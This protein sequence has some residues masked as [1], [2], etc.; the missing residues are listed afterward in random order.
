MSNCIYFIEFTP[1]TIEYKDYLWLFINDAYVLLR[2][3]VEWTVI[4][5]F[6]ITQE[7]IMLCILYNLIN[8]SEV[9][10]SSNIMSYD[11][12]TTKS[13][14]T[15]TKL[16]M[17][18]PEY[19]SKNITIPFNIMKA[20]MPNFNVAKSTNGDI[21]IP[22]E[23]LVLNFDFQKYMDI[24]TDQSVEVI[25]Y[26][27]NLIAFNSILF[28]MSRTTMMPKDFF[29]NIIPSKYIDVMPHELKSFVNMIGNFSGNL[30][31]LKDYFTLPT[32]QFNSD[33]AKFVWNDSRNS[34]VVF[35]NILF[36]FEKF[37]YSMRGIIDISRSSTLPVSGVER[38][39][40]FF[41]FGLDREVS[42]N[43]YR[44]IKEQFNQYKEW[45]F[46]KYSYR[47]S[48]IMRNLIFF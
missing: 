16:G 41:F 46:N 29:D 10:Q 2:K 42:G 18:S 24:I 44:E 34:Y 17:N 6:G 40:V 12:V 21:L 11:D 37:K 14:R 13:W 39:S 30:S 32:D 28:A 25:T 19:T 33:V 45:K 15:R 31:S 5:N 20:I 48:L 22:L 7:L 38:E 36:N 9:T 47:A 35:R 26:I 8:V 23:T 3:D 1:T 27:G 4:H 43:T